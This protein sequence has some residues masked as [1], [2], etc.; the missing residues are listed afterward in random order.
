MKTKDILQNK[1]DDV[2]SLLG[3]TVASKAALIL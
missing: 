2:V 1:G 3:S